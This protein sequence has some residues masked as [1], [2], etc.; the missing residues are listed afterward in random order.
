MFELR[1]V[2]VHRDART[3]L[4]GVS[5]SLPD[6][7][8]TVLAGASGSG[9]SSLLRLL[10]RLDPVSSGTVSWRGAD[11]TTIDAQDLR[12]RVAMVFQRPSMFAVT[13]LDNLR[14]VRADLDE[15]EAAALVTDLGLRPD[16]LT[17]DAAALSGGEAQ[18]ICLARALT[19]GPEV[20]LADE[21]TSGLDPT[22]RRNLEDLAVRM[23]AGDGR[24]PI[25]WIWVSHDEL[26]IRR[27]ADHVAV[28]EDGRL[29]ATGPLDEVVASPEPR[30]RAALGQG[31]TG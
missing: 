16:V 24:G 7:G 28:L 12:R 5:C 20:I 10:N 19:T 26:Q 23:A 30:V 4:D 6:A 11:V 18:R 9:K 27:V 14:A 3:V 21:V 29:L 13:V 25:G 1:D 22:A 17:Q 2:S 15:D 31:G 8:I